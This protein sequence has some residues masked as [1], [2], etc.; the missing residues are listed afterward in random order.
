[1]LKK[2]CCCI[3]LRSGTIT[4]AFLSLTSNLSV[5]FSGDYSASSTIFFII[6]SIISLIGFIGALKNDAKMVEAFAR[7]YWYTVI[8]GFMLTALVAFLLFSSDPKETCKRMIDNHETNMDLE[9]CVSSIITTYILVMV[10]LGVKNLIELHFAYAV[11]AYYQK[12]QEETGERLI[13]NNEISP[14]S[15][16]TNQIPA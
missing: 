5:A 4:L 10:F 9:T 14:P 2:C 16:G 15:Y 7:I 11:W 13:N 12:L 8:L 6:L 3:D 1:M